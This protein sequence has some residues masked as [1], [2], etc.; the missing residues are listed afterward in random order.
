MEVAGV[1]SSAGRG[2]DLP[3]Q[4]AV[5]QRSVQPVSAWPVS[6]RHAPLL[7]QLRQEARG[8]AALSEAAHHPTLLV[9]CRR[10]GEGGR[11]GP[12]VAR[13]AA[14]PGQ[15]PVPLVRGGV[16][17]VHGVSV[18]A[19]A[20][21]GHLRHRRVAPQHRAALGVCDGWLAAQ[22]RAALHGVSQGR[23]PAEDRAALGALAQRRLAAQD[24]AALSSLGQAAAQHGAAAH[25]H[26]EAVGGTGL[27]AQGGHVPLLQDG[28]EDGVAQDVGPVL[29]MGTPVT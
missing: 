17:A 16:A 13:G 1:A 14:L 20:P 24:G 9:S 5:G 8:G 10:D 3:V 2:H 15:V 18:Q 11:G 27:L 7:R 22:H 4:G 29:G 28:G 26:L 6:A 19:G 12:L 23:L 21:L 25:T